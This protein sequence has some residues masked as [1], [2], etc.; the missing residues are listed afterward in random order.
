LL[1][2]QS[3]RPLLRALV[4]LPS[5]SV[6]LNLIPLLLNT[7]LLCWSLDLLYTVRPVGCLSFS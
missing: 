1:V 6:K 5:R 3:A 7:L 2:P 4:S